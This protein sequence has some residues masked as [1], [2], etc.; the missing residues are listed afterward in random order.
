MM[1]KG[2]VTFDGRI[3]RT[4]M[5]IIENIKETLTIEINGLK[6][7]ITNLDGNYE[8]A[9]DIMLQCNGKVIVTGMGKSGLIGQKIAATL[10][11]TGTSSFFVHPG[12]A[13]HGDMGM[14]QPND[15][16]IL[17]SYSGETEELLRMLA[18]L[19]GSSVKTISISGNPNSS[20][21]LNSDTHLNGHISKEACPLELAPTTSTTAALAIGD[22][23][24][25]SLMHLKNFKPEDFAK[26]HPG[27]SLGR[28]LLTRVKDEMRTENLPF[29]DLSA[30][31]EKLL[32]TM[33]EGKLGMAIV[34]TPG[35]VLGVITD[36]DLR[37][38]I[39]KH[40]S[41]QRF[42]LADIYSSAPIMVNEN[43][44]IVDV[45]SKMK[46]HK[47]TTMLVKDATDKNLIGV[48]QIFN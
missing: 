43:D 32:L 26:Y 5:N 28:K 12:E 3:T 2:N 14:I 23:L 4:I 25:V 1:L 24:A 31:N 21:A 8:T 35:N 17:I 16:L 27:G 9:I 18:A 29:I 20:L 30:D 39:L 41:I 40:G 19:R 42:T 45:E 33:S 22:A 6:E 38:A 48:Y 10:S 11:S 36:G 13:L 47:I 46:T 34:G 37:R 7:V 44:K 15:V